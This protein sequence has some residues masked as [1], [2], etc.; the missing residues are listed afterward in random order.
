G[1][2]AARDAAREGERRRVSCRRSPL[3]SAADPALPPLMPIKPSPGFGIRFELFPLTIRQR[4]EPDAILVFVLGSSPPFPIARGLQP[5]LHRAHL[6]GQRDT[7]RIDLP[8]G[9]LDP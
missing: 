1:G 6:L 9:V 2:A 8:L 4:D 5:I 3:S 7:L